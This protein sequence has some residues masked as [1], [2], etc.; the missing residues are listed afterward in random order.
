MDVR[1][2]DQFLRGTLR[3]WSIAAPIK[4]RVVLPSYLCL[5]RF[6]NLFHIVGGCSSTLLA[7]HRFFGSIDPISAHFRPR[8][9][10]TARRCS[11]SCSSPAAHIGG[12]VRSMHRSITDCNPNLDSDS[13]L[14][15]DQSPSSGESMVTSKGTRTAQNT[16]ARRYQSNEYVGGSVLRNICNSDWYHLILRGHN[17]TMANKDKRGHATCVCKLPWFCETQGAHWKRNGRNV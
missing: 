12:F 9:D 4:S 11:S 16:K 14:R 10:F 3:T 5:A 7:S 1:P 13:S 8:A 15:P 2:D 17:Q 6:P